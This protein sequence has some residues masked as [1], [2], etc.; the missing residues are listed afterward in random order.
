[1]SNEEARRTAP[2]GAPVGPGREEDP[3][4]MRGLLLGLG[5]FGRMFA[6]D[7]HLLAARMSRP[8]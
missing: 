4:V 1:M 2:Q 8:R 5:Q 7:V 6:H 3:A